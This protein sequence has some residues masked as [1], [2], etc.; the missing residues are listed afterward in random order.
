[1]TQSGAHQYLRT[2]T[3]TAEHLLIDLGR[4]EVDLS[5][6]GIGVGRRRRFLRYV[7]DRVEPARAQKVIGRGGAGVR[8][9]D[10]RGLDCHRREDEGRGSGGR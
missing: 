7:Q 5:A 2:H 4:V 6:P 3:L 9:A 8:R 1:M 10:G